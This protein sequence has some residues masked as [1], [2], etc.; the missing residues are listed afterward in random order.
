MLENLDAQNIPSQIN[1]K[2]EKLEKELKIGI[3]DGKLIED[4]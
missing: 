4:R 1:K 3:P 2:S